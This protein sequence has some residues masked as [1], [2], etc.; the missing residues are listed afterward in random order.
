MAYFV[1]TNLLLP[2]LKAGRAHRLHRVRRAQGR[3]SSISTICNRKELFAASPSMANP[4]SATSC[5]TANWRGASKAPASPPTA[6]IRASSP[7]ASATRA[8]AS[9]QTAIKIAKP[10]GAISPEE[11]AKTIVYLASS[12]EVE[13]KSGGYYYKNKPRHPDQGS[14]ERRRREAAVG[15]LGRAFRRGRLNPCPPKVTFRRR[16]AISCL[17]FDLPV[18]GVR[19]R[20]VRLDA[21]STRALERACAARGRVARARRDAGAGGAARHRAEARRAADGADQERRRARSRHRRLLRRGRR[22]SRA[23]CA[24][25]RG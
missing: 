17:P 4:S 16:R 3:A 1:V 18:V 2:K 20:L 25:L 23:A 6:C 5:S 19:G 9:V 15:D 21:A 7:R 22:A 8:A 24:A 14:A 12:P 13:G 10:I 11:G